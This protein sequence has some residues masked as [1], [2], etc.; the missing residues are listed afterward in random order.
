MFAVP[1]DVTINISTQW[2]FCDPYHPLII[3]GNIRTTDRI[4]IVASKVIIEKTGSITAKKG[5]FIF[6]NFFSNRGRIFS[7]QGQMIYNIAMP[8]FLPYMPMP[9]FHPRQCL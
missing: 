7:P 8:Y 4:Y 2:A 5:L 6:T 1:P 9:Y 3:A